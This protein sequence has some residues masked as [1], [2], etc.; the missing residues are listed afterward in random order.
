MVLDT[1]SRIR[2]GKYFNYTI[3]KEEFSP[4]EKVFLFAKKFCN[5]VAELQNEIN[6]NKKSKKEIEQLKNKLNKLLGIKSNIDNQLNN[7][8]YGPYSNLGKEL[9]QKLFLLTLSSLNKT[10]DGSCL[11]ALIH[12]SEYRH[13]KKF[14]QSVLA[15]NTD[16]IISY[17]SHPLRK[18]ISGMYHTKNEIPP[19][20]EINELIEFVCK[21]IDEHLYKDIYD[22]IMGEKKESDFP[23]K[24]EIKELAKKTR[25]L[26]SS[27]TGMQNGGGI[28]D[29]GK[30]RSLKELC[31]EFDEDN[32]QTI[33]S[34]ITGMQCGKGIP[35]YDKLQNLFKTI[36]L[37][38]REEQ[39]PNL[40]ELAN[41]ELNPNGID[42]IIFQSILRRI[43]G[44]RNGLCIPSPKECVGLI[45]VFD[46]IK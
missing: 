11:T 30:I 46:D 36:I 45:K 38:M 2:S 20:E 25:E 6:D 9:E 39:I 37:F 41:I 24:S 43:S 33:F 18:S 23:N 3:R 12:C 13:V 17:S 8:S 16:N 10:H 27:I 35:N 1:I 34:S 29:F 7:K 22:Y 19:I 14:L 42:K 26:F 44:K 40:E 32:W 31:E 28:P 5:E 21:I 4:L 15:T